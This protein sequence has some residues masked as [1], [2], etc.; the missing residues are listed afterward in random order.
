MTTKI[1]V[2]T[3]FSGLLFLLFAA[4]KAETASVADVLAWLLAGVVCLTVSYYL[5]V[6]GRRVAKRAKRVKAAL[7]GAGKRT[8]RVR[9][10]SL[11]EREKVPG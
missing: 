4:G 7:F 9:K 10:T 3:A 5:S 6:N 11:A 2:I 1:S 8:R